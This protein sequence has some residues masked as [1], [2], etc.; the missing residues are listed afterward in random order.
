MGRQR[1]SCLLS[2]IK[3]RTLT[4]SAFSGL[5]VQ[6]LMASS[7]VDTRRISQVTRHD[8]A[9]LGLRAYNESVWYTVWRVVRDEQVYGFSNAA[10][11]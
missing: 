8:I 11:A 5:Q 9:G 3:S 7:P 4:A 10:T 6:V 2:Q 1:P